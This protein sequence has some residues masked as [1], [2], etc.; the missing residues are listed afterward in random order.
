[1]RL[2]L[3]QAHPNEAAVSWGRRHWRGAGT[4]AGAWRP[5]SERPA[6]DMRPHKGKVFFAVVPS[7]VQ[8]TTFGMIVY[9]TMFY[10]R[11]CLA[12]KYINKC[13]FS[14]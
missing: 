7:K 2:A 9:F 13:V 4:S 3:R 1:M 5:S 6:E 14:Q 12:Y 8:C 11:K 10:I